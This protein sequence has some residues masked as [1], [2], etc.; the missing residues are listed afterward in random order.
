MSDPVRILPS[1]P[2]A[3]LAEYASLEDVLAVAER[4]RGDLP[5]GVVDVVPA[6]RTI[7]I[8]VSPGTPL[9]GV[10]AALVR[11]PSGLPAAA[12]SPLVTV[13]V[14]YDGADLAAVADAC[15]MDVDEV[16]VAHTSREYTAA[17][18][19]FMPGFS[20]LVGLDPRLHLPR[21]ATPRTRVPPGSVAIAA[22]FS[23]VYPQ[24][25]PGGWHLLG[26]TGASMWDE[27]RAVPALVPP[28]ARVRFVAR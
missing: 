25:A 5:T 27:R 11:V 28:G 3:V 15:G 9:D 13:E 22:E 14:T 6:A 21:R 18:C 12:G 8:T 1:G 19:G 26:T 24:A 16:V 20:Y 23:A 7:L 10:A 17:F 4:L 2:R